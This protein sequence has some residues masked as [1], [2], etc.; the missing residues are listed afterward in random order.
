MYV[1]SLLDPAS[2]NFFI[3]PLK[4]SFHLRINIE[5]DV[6][7]GEYLDCPVEM[8]WF[9][10]WVRIYSAYASDAAAWMQPKKKIFM[11]TDL[12]NNLLPLSSFS[13]PPAIF[14]IIVLALIFYHLQMFILS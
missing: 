9:H 1:P 3:F 4:P 14:V 8:R 2:F 10:P 12:G 13:Y 6:L 5:L 7:Y 11:I